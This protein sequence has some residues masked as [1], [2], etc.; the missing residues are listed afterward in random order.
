MQ[1]T[2][3][4]HD[5]LVSTAD[6]QQYLKLTKGTK[7]QHM[8]PKMKLAQNTEVKLTQHTEVREVRKWTNVS[9]GQSF[10][11]CTTD[12]LPTTNRRFRFSGRHGH[13]GLIF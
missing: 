6:S 10:N 9:D 1:C 13:V 12:Q 4:D 2:V 11:V 7:W 8:F 3:R 5:I